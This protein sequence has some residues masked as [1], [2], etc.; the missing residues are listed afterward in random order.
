[1]QNK[2]FSDGSGLDLYDYGARFQDPQL[3]VWHGFDPLADQA[4]RWS[5]CTYAYDNPIRFIDPDGMWTDDANGGIT[6]SDPTE[7]KNFLNGIQQGNAKGGG[8]GKDK[9]G[10]GNKGTKSN[11][12]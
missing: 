6:T 4:R 9:K 1:L 8:N 2:E 5:P 7:I 12:H 3:G 10:G 11:L